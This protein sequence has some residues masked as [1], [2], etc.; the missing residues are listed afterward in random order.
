MK[1]IIVS[2]LLAVSMLLTLSGCIVVNMSVEARVIYGEG[3]IRTFTY[4]V[5]SD[6]FNKIDGSYDVVFFEGDFE[7]VYRKGISDTI[8]IEMQENLK[9]YVSVT[10]GGSLLE[11]KSSEK[12][13]T[14]Y[15]AYPRVTITA[16][17]LVALSFHGIGILKDAD[18][19]GGGSLTL[20]VHGV[21]DIDVDVDVDFIFVNLSGAGGVTLR[22]E[23]DTANFNLSGAG[24]IN[25]LALQTRTAAVSVSGAG[26]GSISVSE[27]LE[28]NISGVGS[29]SYRG[30]PEVRSRISGLGLL[31]KID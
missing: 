4:N 1:R 2:A 15:N 29:F 8:I 7:V 24:N 5:G 17:E 27:E 19:F 14:D 26:G 31:H 6:E 16:P 21:G 25:A 18:T 23:A 28:V 20:G 11:I 30:E 13:R 10:H 9:E 3:P 12:L 22:G